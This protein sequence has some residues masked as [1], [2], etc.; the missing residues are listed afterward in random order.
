MSESFTK[1]DRNKVA[2]FLS[3]VNLSQGIG[4]AEMPCSIAAINIALTGK[5]GDTRPSCMSPVIHRFIIEV[6][7]SAGDEMRNSKEWKA[8]LPWAAG[9]LDED[10]IELER[11]CLVRDWLWDTVFPNK[12]MLNTSAL[13]GLRYDWE[14]MLKGRSQQSLNA[15]VVLAEAKS[16]DYA[17]ACAAAAQW[18]LC[19]YS[20]TSAPCCPASMAAESARDACS[21]A[22]VVA[23]Q[24]WQDRVLSGCENW[25][26]AERISCI[27]AA[28]RSFE[29]AALLRRLIEHPNGLP[30][31]WEA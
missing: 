19:T 10:E 24:A 8:L 25:T 20:L 9:S 22:D 31:G 17:G 15:F 16:G 11:L 21:A 29:P 13:A 23:R 5:I 3:T 7:D 28:W 26:G 2:S 1:E 14:A 27:E 6:Q 30:A 12:I 18:A 4:F